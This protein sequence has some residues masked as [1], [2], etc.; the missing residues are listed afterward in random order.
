[1]DTKQGHADSQAAYNELGHVVRQLHESFRE[2]GCD[3]SLQKVAGDLPETKDRLHYI[4]ALTEQA[5]N[6]ALNAVETAMPVQETLA[7][8]ARR[9]SDAWR[10][11]ATEKEREELHQEVQDFLDNVPNHAQVI[12]SQLTEIMMAQDFQDLTGQVIKKVMDMASE[13]EQQLVNILLLGRP[14]ACAAASSDKDVLLNGP[15]VKKEGR[16]DIVGNQQE[17]DDLLDGLGF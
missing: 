8:D 3:E 6:R 16:A 10:N 17:V 1:M 13:L 7:S 9:L 5:A 15:V 2:L 12:G 4:V 11:A 14:A